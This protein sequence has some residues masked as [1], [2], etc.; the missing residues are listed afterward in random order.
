MTDNKR[1]KIKYPKPKTIVKPNNYSK[2]AALMRKT[3]VR[4]NFGGVE[5]E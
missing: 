3:Y 1:Y 4:K 2:L 5:D